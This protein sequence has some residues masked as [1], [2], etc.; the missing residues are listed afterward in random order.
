MILID[1]VAGP[2][3]INED[4][5]NPKWKI[6]IKR[7]KIPKLKAETNEMII[8]QGVISLDVQAKDCQVRD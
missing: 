5:S 7:L 6:R 3:S 1:T 4:N 2:N 8:I